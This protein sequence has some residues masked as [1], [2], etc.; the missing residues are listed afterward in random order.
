MAVASIPLYALL[1]ATPQAQA[2][3]PDL[4]SQP[5]IYPVNPR[6]SAGG[7]QNFRELYVDPT[8]F[9]S[10]LEPIPLPKPPPV[11]P[12]RI[13]RERIALTGA[14]TFVAGSADLTSEAKV[15]LDAVA[16]T[17]RD[18]PGILEV[19]IEA[20]SQ[21][22]GSTTRTR[23]LAE[24]RAV[25]VRDYLVTKGVDA[26][27]LAPVGLGGATGAD[28]PEVSLRISKWDD[29]ALASTHFAPA[30]TPRIP[31]VVQQVQAQKGPV[32]IPVMNDR[33]GWAKVTVNGH[34]VGII[35]PL[36]NGAIEGV[37]P[38]V[39]EVH[40]TYSDSSEFTC[41]TQTL[42]LGGP[43]APGGND[44]KAVIDDPDL[45]PDWWNHPDKAFGSWPPRCL[46]PSDLT[47]ASTSA[48]GAEPATDNGPSG[49]EVAGDGATTPKN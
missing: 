20:R 27:R 17:L 14:I 6:L 8:S 46:A 11:E 26:L 25:A 37:Q 40:Y 4:P 29:K 34:D 42:P 35:G 39:Y 23:K 31:E 7:I 49:D 18:N 48:P 1:T 44:A 12:V 22:A 24:Q 10:E 28:T 41:L 30:D 3:T 5:V 43:L 21:E 2:V 15:L 32:A 33:T 36:T 9:G 47:I 19:T 13:T 16:E 38:G 45:V